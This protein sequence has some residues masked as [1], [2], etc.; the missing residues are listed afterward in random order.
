[1]DTMNRRQVIVAVWAMVA[2]AS[3]PSAAAP[4][5]N[6][7]VLYA[8][9]LGYGDVQ[10]YNADRGRIPTPNIDRL[11][12]EG[13]RFTDAHSSGSVCTPSR[14]T[15]LTGRYHWR[16]RLQSG[17]ASTTSPALITPDRLTIAGLV[18]QHGYRT[19]C[20]GKWHLGLGL[21]I[22]EGEM[23][24]LFGGEAVGEE[25]DRSLTARERRKKI[26]REWDALTD[27]DPAPP[28]D[29]ADAAVWK[30]FFSRRIP[31]GPCS[32]GFDEYF[33]VDMPNKPPFCFIEHDRWVGTPTAY[34]TP[35]QV[36]PVFLAYPNGPA[37]DGWRLEK[38]SPAIEARTVA[39]LEQAAGKAPFLMYVALTTPH[40]PLAV[41]EPWRGKSGLGDYADLV[42]ETDAFVG[43][44]MQVL[45]K[46]GLAGNT[47]VVFTSDNGFAT[48]VGTAELEKRGHYP[49]GPLRGYKGENHEGG[50]RV[51]FIVRYP[52]V[53]TPGTVCRQHVQQADVMRTL[54]DILG[55]TLP[56]NAGEDSFSM[57]PLLR[58]ED[59]PI[60]DHGVNTSVHGV[61]AIRE[62][63]WKLILGPNDDREE[64]A[65]ASQRGD[66]LPVDPQSVQLYD[67]AADL[68]ETRN[69]ADA[70]PE[71]VQR[72]QAILEKLIRDGR[73]TPGKPQANDEEVIRHPRPPATQRNAAL[74]APHLSIHPR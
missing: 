35:K 39:C 46:T 43:R 27:A 34:L 25:G 29:P 69:L 32:V 62:A 73:S 28:V 53:V 5:P 71:R 64:R 30:D 10:C 7:I 24:R 26:V 55:A 21:D 42:M 74:A 59:R 36:R 23:T 12:A 15:L 50:H 57:L 51:P 41:N 72:M 68:A 19:I 9:D 60:R 47:L 2:S 22:R 1:M 67:L 17:I 54:A 3:I 65:K 44:V 49:S 38:V 13:M 63:N 37:I 33:G 14:Y 56:E 70:Q 11:A 45:E 4:R 16:S 18:K 8:D 52:G 58:G 66:T 40:T 6:V 31:A 61:P 48:Y 20:L